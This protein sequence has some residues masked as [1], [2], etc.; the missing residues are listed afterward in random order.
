MHNS[1]VFRVI[2]VYESLHTEMV[3]MLLT[4]LQ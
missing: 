2:H 4:T 3:G 1:T